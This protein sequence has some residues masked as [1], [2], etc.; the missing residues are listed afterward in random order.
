MLFFP[1]YNIPFLLSWAKKPSW[2]WISQSILLQIN[3]NFKLSILVLRNKDKQLIKLLG[4]IHQL[5]PDTSPGLFMVSHSLGAF[6][7]AMDSTGDWDQLLWCLFFCWSL[8]LTA[9]LWRVVVFTS[10][11]P[12]RVTPPPASSVCL[13]RLRGFLFSSTCWW[14]LFAPVVLRL[15]AST[16]R[17]VTSSSSSQI[18]PAVPSYQAPASYA[19]CTCSLFCGN[20]CLLRFNLAGS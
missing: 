9:L 1:F 10:R 6:T 12:S 5:A 15:S 2:V 8:F 18:S 13:P 19:Q 20:F 4:E 16:G 11:G 14:Q 7:E 3:I 17:S